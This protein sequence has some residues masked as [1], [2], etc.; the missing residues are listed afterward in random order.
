MNVLRIG[1]K[2]KGEED[3][4][5]ATLLPISGEAMRMAVLTAAATAASLTLG[6]HFLLLRSRLG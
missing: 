1:R 4:T 5:D 3:G 2:K 6:D